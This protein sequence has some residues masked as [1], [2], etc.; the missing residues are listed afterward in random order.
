MY[1]H[2]CLHVCMCVREH[3]HVSLQ[4]GVCKQYTIQ[5]YTSIHTYLYRYRNK[6]SIMQLTSKRT[7][8]PEFAT[9]SISKPSTDIFP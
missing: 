1:I 4:P 2:V 9:F 5:T 8:A 3:M 6:H 7:Q